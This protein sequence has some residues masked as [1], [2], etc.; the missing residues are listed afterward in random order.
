[1]ANV[2][3]EVDVMILNTYTGEEF[4][5]WK[6]FSLQDSFLTPCAQFSLTAGSNISPLEIA[7]KLPEGSPVKIYVNGN[8]QLTGFVDSLS[9]SS[10]RGGSEV[11]ISGRDFL[12]QLV[13]GNIDPNFNKPKEVTIE[14]LVKIVLTDQFRIDAEIDLTYSSRNIATGKTKKTTAKPTKS[15]THSNDPLKSTEVQGNEGAFQYLSRILAYHGYWMR[16]S[17]DGGK[18]IL[19]PPEYD[20]DFSAILW[21][22]YAKDP[23]SEG[24]IE[25]SKLDLNGTS[26]P[27]DVFVRGRDS[28]AGKRGKVYA[29]IHNQ[30]SPRWKPVYVQDEMAKDQKSAETIARSFMAKQQRNYLKYSCTVKGFTNEHTKETYN[31]DTVVDV[32]D[33]PLGVRGLWWVETRNFTLSRSGASTELNVIPLG[34]LVLDWQPDEQISPP[35]YWSEALQ[36]S[37]ERKA[38]YKGNQLEYRNLTVFPRTNGVGQ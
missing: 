25:G 38:L 2:D 26:V 5:Y 31:V 14:Q 1:M 22:R 6:S 12:S 34:T 37:E 21:K 27:S 23:Q 15:R 19:A 32:Y 9:L 8:I 7:R 4:L 28:G 18:V 35:L 29:T 13:D 11:I 30:L 33:E 3:R 10:N 17:P 20:Q 16:A 24:N 36:T